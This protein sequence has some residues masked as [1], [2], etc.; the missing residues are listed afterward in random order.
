MSAVTVSRGESVSRGEQVGRIGA[1]GLATGPHCHF[2]V[3]VGRIWDG[4]TRVNPLKYF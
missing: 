3:W 1:S 2:E 4:G